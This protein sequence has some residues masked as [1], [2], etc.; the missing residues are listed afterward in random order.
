MSNTANVTRSTPTFKNEAHISGMLAQD[1]TV[2]YTSSG[3]LV[4]NCTVITKHEQYTE[5]HKIVLW[6]KLA[7]RVENLHKGDWV[8]VVGRLQTRSWQDKQ[9]EQKKY[10]TEI[11]GFQL[12]VPSQEPQ[13]NAHGTEGAADDGAF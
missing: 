13:S 4:T 10:S 11:V 12:S 3:K 7:E 8:R 2:R 9:S 6:E 5:F 1:P